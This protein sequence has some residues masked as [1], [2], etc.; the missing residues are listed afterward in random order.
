MQKY[1]ITETTSY[2]GSQLRSLFAYMEHEILGDSIVA[3]RGACDIS[4]DNMVDGE[5]LLAGAEIRGSDMIHFIMECF[6]QTLFAAVGFQRLF[7]N[8]VRDV[9]YEMNPKWAGMM[10][11]KGDDL[12]FDQRKLSISIAT[13]SPVSALVHFAVNV[14]FEGTPVPTIGLRDLEVDP[15]DFANKVMTAWVEEYKSMKEATQKVKWVK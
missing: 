3:W 14:N 9:I 6:D 13:V 4:N 11:R 10:I 7:T 8:I 5:D 2:D 1:W 12:Y 15:T